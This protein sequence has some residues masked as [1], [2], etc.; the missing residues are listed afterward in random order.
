MKFTKNLIFLGILMLGTVLAFLRWKAELTFPVLSGETG[1]AAWDWIQ[2]EDSP[3][4]PV[5]RQVYK[6][7]MNTPGS[8]ILPGDILKKIEYQPVPSS[9]LIENILQASAPGKILIYQVEREEVNV[10][11]PVRLNLLV[12]LAWK[13]FFTSAQRPLFW[14]L[15]FLLSLFLGFFTLII[16]LILYP[17]IRSS[18]KKNLPVL[19]VLTLS[20]VAFIWYAF[21]TLRIRVDFPSSLIFQEQ[22]FI[23]GW[24]V[25]SSLIGLMALMALPGRR[26]WMKTLPALLILAGF[27]YLSGISLFHTE[28]FR[29]HAETLS[30][31]SIFFISVNNLWF[32]ASDR[33]S[34]ILKDFPWFK[35]LAMLIILGML[36]V[37]GLQLVG[38]TLP[39]MAGSL[40][41][42]LVFPTLFLPVLDLSASR[43]K[44][45]KATV[46]LTRTIQYL[47]FSGAVF[48]MYLLLSWILELLY[49]GAPFL[50]WITLI[51][52]IMAVLA[53]RAVYHRNKVRF[54]RMGVSFQPRQSEEI[55]QFIA[56][57]P[58][59]THSQHLIKEAETYILKYFGAQD[60]LFWLEEQDEATVS[61]SRIYLS[62]FKGLNLPEL[63]WSANK[64][65]SPLTLQ[66]E[67]EQFLL[68]KNW[69]LALPLR[70]SRAKAGLLILGK[71]K[72]GVYNLEDLDLLRR[73]S[74]Q[75]WLTLD[76]LYLLENEKLLMQKTME[77]NMTALRSQ[78]NP[79][80]LFNTLNTISSL[81]HDNPEMAE[82]AVENLAFIFRYTLRTSGENFVTIENEMSL[83]QKYLEI[84]QFR[85]GDN[86]EIHLEVD[87]ACKECELPALV[88]QTIVENC[89]KHGITKIVTK[90]IVS[91]RIK[92]LGEKFQAIIEDNGPGIRSDRISMGTGLNNIHSR[93]HSLYENGDILT[94]E[95]TGKG[96]RVTLTLPKKRHEK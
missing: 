27:T 65:L 71:K 90:G 6:V 26:P 54:N 74:T 23:L 93:L 10:F 56:S 66:P 42:I 17:L 3:R 95:N 47:L 13:P 30:F 78:I 53:G 21:R 92:D 15:E 61:E 88:I 62:V 82:Q 85:F 59:Y 9:A 34:G 96:T 63:F 31:F 33:E 1:L 79:H 52:L 94:F 84:E 75:I 83:V 51:L 70:F 28:D 77:A 7:A 72:K 68:R 58:R 91:I 41:E 16:L 80:F 39:E 20:L 43:L 40:A 37:S 60:V 49:P 18:W 87:E 73:I 11:N 14:N 86:L 50:E 89:I 24:L 4:G 22:V 38:M 2:W 36:V 46:V 55:Q 12:S 69:S 32:V 25:L 45:G 76:I 48:V 44:F 35:L 57:I 67:D 29:E 19:G 64:E 8:G 81:I 5:A